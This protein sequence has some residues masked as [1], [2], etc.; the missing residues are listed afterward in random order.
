M[1]DWID[2][3]GLQFGVASIVPYDEVFCLPTLDWA[4]KDCIGVM[5]VDKKDVVHATC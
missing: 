3:S 2:P 1:K 5:I 4:N